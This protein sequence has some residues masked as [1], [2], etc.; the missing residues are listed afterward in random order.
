MTIRN[1]F[2]ICA[3]IFCLSASAL[4]APAFSAPVELICTAQGNP[5]PIH[6]ALDLDA[7]TVSLWNDYMPRGSEAGM[8]NLALTVDS[9]K[10]TWQSVVDKPTYSQTIDY[11]LDRTTLTL[12]TY[13]KISVARNGVDGTQSCQR[14]QKQL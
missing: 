14:A 1:A 13:S 6:L 10:V 9:D 7:R 5:S 3:A 4:F 2:V 11:M 12:T 8:T